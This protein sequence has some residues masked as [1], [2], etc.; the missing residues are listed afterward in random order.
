MLKVRM[1]SL[2]IENFKNVEYGKIEMPSKDIKIINNEKTEILGVYGQN[3]SGK[4]TVIDAIDLFKRILLG[5]EL[6]IEDKDLIYIGKER[7]KLTYTFY[8]TENGRVTYTEYSVAIKI[9]EKDKPIICGE[10]L[11][12]SAY[13]KGKW[14]TKRTICDFEEGYDDILIKPK[15]RW[16]KIINNNKENFVDIAVAKR[17]SIKTGK[18]F[19]FSDE[20]VEVLSETF[21]DEEEINFSLKSLMK[22]AKENLFVIKT[23]CQ[24]NNQ[25]QLFLPE[26]HKISL[27]EKNIV[28]LEEFSELKKMIKLENI[29]IGL[30]IPN[31]ELVIKEYGRHL[32]ND[33]RE[34]IA[35]E[36][37]SKKGNME[38]PLRAESGG[39]KRIITLLNILLSVFTQEEVCLAIDELDAGL[40]EYLYGKLIKLI[41]IDGKGQLI[42]TS[43]NMRPLE[44][45]NKKS[46]IFATANPKNKYIR[47]ANVRDNN[48][49][50]DLY[51]KSAKLDG[52]KEILYLEDDELKLKEMIHEINI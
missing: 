42:F 29:A 46:L 13:N 15:Y 1:S 22:F 19:I 43:N 14:S 24:E 21:K 40:H 30:F 45:I 36:S 26:M 23:N 34:G 7:A 50:R 28:S 2:E 20:I 9:N 52:Q 12:I 31:T 4:T 33:G 10:K 16:D 49:L 39:I 6:K 44:L 8:I 17:I 27:E 48:N 25:I 3:G 35:F 5:E 38:I 47:F 11:I 51:L 37:M 41:E 18:T 32:D